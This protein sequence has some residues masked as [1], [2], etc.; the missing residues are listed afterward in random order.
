ML[1]LPGSQAM[2]ALGPPGSQAVS[3]LGP[4]LGSALTYLSAIVHAGDRSPRTVA[5]SGAPCLTALLLGVRSQTQADR[6]PREYT[7]LEFAG[8][9]KL[10]TC[11]QRPE[12]PGS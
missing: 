4:P 8:Q 9:S 7:E 1:C 11:Q 10:G 3:A 5:D 6:R 12:G 2:S